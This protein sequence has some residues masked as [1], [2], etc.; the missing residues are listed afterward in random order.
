MK[1]LDKITNKQFTVT[2][3][4]D[5]VY[6]LKRGSFAIPNVTTDKYQIERIVD[7]LNGLNVKDNS[8][9]FELAVRCLR[10]KEH[11][12]YSVIKTGNTYG[13]AY[14]DVE[15]ADITTNKN[16]AVQIVNLLNGIVDKDNDVIQEI[17]KIIIDYKDLV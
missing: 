2:Q 17:I 13:I 9:V 12:V 1:L 3:T 6:G 11:N 5:N 8:R 10:F 14:A 16:N 4:P 15:L 7:L